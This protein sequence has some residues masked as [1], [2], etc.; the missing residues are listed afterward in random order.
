MTTIKRTHEVMAI[1][2]PSQLTTFNPLGKPGDLLYVNL[3]KFTDEELQKV[4]DQFTKDL[5]AR[6]K[7]MRQGAQNQAQLGQ[8]VKISKGLIG[9]IAGGADVCDRKYY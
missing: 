9:G 1:G 4:G 5:L 7:E 2:V 6:A 3:N 8:A